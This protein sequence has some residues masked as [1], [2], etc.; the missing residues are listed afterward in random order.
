M[1]ENLSPEAESSGVTPPRAEPELV[2]TEVNFSAALVELK[3]LSR[4]AGEV[5]PTHFDPRF[6]VVLEIERVEGE[7][8]ALAPGRRAFAIHSPS[9]LFG[10]D[11]ARQRGRRHD[12]AI[13][14]S[15][16]GERAWYSGL[17][18]Q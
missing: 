3:P 8:A 15:R 2:T 5:T 9:R 6:V 18:L 11:A 12:F 16:Q 7:G 13:S 10:G 14:W 1:T 17:R 4:Y